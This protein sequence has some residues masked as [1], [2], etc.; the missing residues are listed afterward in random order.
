MKGF[1][2]DR[3]TCYLHPCP[4]EFQLRGPHFLALGLPQDVESDAPRPKRLRLAAVELHPSESQAYIEPQKELGDGDRVP[5]ALGREDDHGIVYERH[6]PSPRHRQVCP[7]LSQEA[8]GCSLGVL[9]KRK[10]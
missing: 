3:D 2:P 1:D 10:W 8:P 9:P 6:C 5:R 4:D 7:E